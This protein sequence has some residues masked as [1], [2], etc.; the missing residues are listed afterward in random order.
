MTVC[1]CNDSW[2]RKTGPGNGNCAHEL[3]AQMI[4]KGLVEKFDKKVYACCDEGRL[5]KARSVRDYIFPVGLLLSF[6][7]ISVCT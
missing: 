5:L 1:P 4:A 2:I 6:T 7:S 3:H